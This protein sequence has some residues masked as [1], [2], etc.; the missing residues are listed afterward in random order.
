VSHRTLVAVAAEEGY[1]YRT[2]RRV[3]DDAADARRAVAAGPAER[4]PDL[5]A[6]VD[7]VRFDR[8]EALVV[9]SADGPAR[10]YCVLPSSCGPLRDPPRSDPPDG[11]LLVAVVGDREAAEYR[12]MWEGAR[13]VAA[14]ALDDG[15]L[16]PAAARH[17][18]ARALARLT[19]DR[20][21]VDRTGSGATAGRL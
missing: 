21:V 7:A 10:R 1:E 20:E 12:R 11:G 3:P 9:V 13:A 4:A 6:V 19:G 8:H 2:V 15:W 17:L 5:T 18:L 14:V 16:S